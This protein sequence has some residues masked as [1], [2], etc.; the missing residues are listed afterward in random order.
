[1][2]DWC[3]RL[4]GRRGDCGSCGRGNEAVYCEGVVDEL[5]LLS[6]AFLLFRSLLGDDEVVEGVTVLARHAR[7][8]AVTVTAIIVAATAIIRIIRLIAVASAFAASFASF[9]I[10]RHLRVLWDC[11][12]SFAQTLGCG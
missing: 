3:D 7:G 6:G 8:V 5:G 1:M 12:I 9:S 10:G 4:G 2:N 11:W